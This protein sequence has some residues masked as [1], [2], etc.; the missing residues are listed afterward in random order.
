MPGGCRGDSVKLR[1]ADLQVADLARFT[2]G[3]YCP[4]NRQPRK[5]AASRIS[6]ASVVSLTRHTIPDPP[7]RPREC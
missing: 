7:Y 5:S 1:S 6:S 4:V 2:V 3:E